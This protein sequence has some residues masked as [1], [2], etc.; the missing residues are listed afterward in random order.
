MKLFQVFEETVTSGDEMQLQENGGD[1]INSRVVTGR[2]TLD[3]PLGSNVW[4]VVHC[5][6]ADAVDALEAVSPSGRLY[7]L[8]LV[9]DGLIHIRIAQTNEFGEWRYRL[10]F[11]QQRT[12][13]TVQVSAEPTTATSTA[14]TEAITVD[15][16]TLSKE[17]QQTL[18]PL[19]LP[20]V[21]VYVQVKRGLR[22]VMNARV[23]VRLRRQRR[24]L[25]IDNETSIDEDDVIQQ[26]RLYDRG[27]GG[28]KIRI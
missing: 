3:E 9:A 14:A 28:R 22:P 4:L 13:V 8:P 25:A 6:D 24:H 10:R 11:A 26:F 23:N 1:L 21:V 19:P 5:D 18:T 17:Q 20:L 7:D 2:F 16:W 15:A 12:A 27:T